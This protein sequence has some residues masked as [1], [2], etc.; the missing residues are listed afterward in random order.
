MKPSNSNILPTAP[1]SLD[2]SNSNII[3]PYAIIS[4]N[5]KSHLISNVNNIISA[6]NI[7]YQ[8][9]HHISKQDKLKSQII[10]SN[11]I[12]NK[13]DGDKIVREDHNATKQSKPVGI[14]KQKE[15]EHKLKISNSLDSN[16]VHNLGADNPIPIAYP[17]TNY[18]T[19]NSIVNQKEGTVAN[20]SKSYEIS[21]YK[22][23][24]EKN[25][26]SMDYNIQEYK[27]MYE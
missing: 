15:V 25:N 27:S 24:Y 1:I 26:G 11:P 19:T 7:Q 12:Y 4:E 9:D 10:Q 8:P 13:H 5:E 21:E 22:S 20:K 16:N 18:I 14:I 23:I 6:E 2:K 17:D 3:E